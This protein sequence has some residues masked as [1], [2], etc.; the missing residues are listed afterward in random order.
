MRRV[1]LIVF[2]FLG[3]FAF[4]HPAA[5]ERK[6]VQVSSKVT[7]SPMV[8]L[9]PN[10]S[11][12]LNKK[13]CPVAKVLASNPEISGLL[14]ELVTRKKNDKHIELRLSVDNETLQSLVNLF[15]TLSKEIELAR[16]Q[17]QEADVA[18]WLAVRA[19][20]SAVKKERCELPELCAMLQAAD[21]LQAPLLKE[22]IAAVYA[23][24]LHDVSKGTENRSKDI[25]ARA[26]ELPTGVKEAVG[27]MF[28][29]QYGKHINTRLAL[30]SEVCTADDVR[31]YQGIALL[32]KQF[33]G[34]EQNP[35]MVITFARG[36]SPY[37]Y[38]YK[39]TPLLAL[40]DMHNSPFASILKEASGNAVNDAYYATAVRL[41]LPGLLKMVLRMGANPNF[42]PVAEP[43]LCKAMDTYLH[44]KIPAAMI[45]ILLEQG[46]DIS[47]IG[48]ST[49]KLAKPVLVNPDEQLRHTLLD[50]IVETGVTMNDVIS[51][52]RLAN[53]VSL[54]VGAKRYTAAEELATIREN[55]DEYLA[56]REAK[57]VTF[58]A[59]GEFLNFIK[60]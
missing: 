53:F 44:G 9:I 45:A 57:G 19:V 14:A 41:P 4:A 36:N 58:P 39:M 32:E 43:L 21:Y 31:L 55:L 59:W 18:H 27:R 49:F 20:A 51:S 28:V 42:S 16:A 47:V 25:W 29:L 3:F 54:E 48:D 33:P 8:T 1:L 56:Y 23:Q 12:L 11:S 52:V 2:L 50:R 6:G 7:S 13:R 35:N 5:I 40:V 15:P 22:G 24:L 26:A 37:R 30:K 38:E 34:F 60:A 46:A 10:N 17:G